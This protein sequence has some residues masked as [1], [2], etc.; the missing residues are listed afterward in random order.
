MAVDHQMVVTLENAVAT[1]NR[2]AGSWFSQFNSPAINPIVDVIS[3]GTTPSTASATSIQKPVRKP[4]LI[5]PLLA[6]Q[7][8]SQQLMPEMPAL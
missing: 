5:R 4:N 7:A 3:S 6:N 8:T 1:R 2:S